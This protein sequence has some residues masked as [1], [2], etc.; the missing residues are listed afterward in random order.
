MAYVYLLN[1]YEKLDLRLDETS[2]LISDKKKTVHEINCLE[3]RRDVLLEFKQFLSDN[4]NS[5]LPKRIRKRLLNP[6]G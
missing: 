1:L 2:V 6:G 5:R 3:G 4:L